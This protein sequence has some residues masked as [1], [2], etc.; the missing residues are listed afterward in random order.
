MYSA[1]NVILLWF[2]AITRGVNWIWINII[3]IIFVYTPRLLYTVVPTRATHDVG[4]ADPFRK[5]WER[6]IIERKLIILN[7]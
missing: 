4:T 1:Y 7:V 6:I 3:F 2:S 5:T